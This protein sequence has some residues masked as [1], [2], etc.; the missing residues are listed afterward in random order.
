MDQTEEKMDTVGKLT[1]GK[2]IILFVLSVLLF[3]TVVALFYVIS[4]LALSL[5]EI[6]PVRGFDWVS[7]RRRARW[8]WG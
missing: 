6:V 2:Y 4:L 7:L 8:M 3:S 1:L 5:H